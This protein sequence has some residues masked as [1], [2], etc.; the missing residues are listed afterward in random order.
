MKFRLFFLLL[1]FWGQLPAQ[2]TLYITDVPNNTPVDA[3]IYVA[4]SFQGWDPG[5]PDYE[6][7]NNGDGTYEIVINPPAGQLKFKFTRGGWD[8][9]EGNANGEYLPDRIYDYDGNGTSLDLTILS[10]EDTGGSGSSTAADNVFILDEDFYMPQLNRNRRIWM[11]LPPD[12]DVSDKYYPVLYMHDGQNL[13]D[14][15]TSFTG[16]WEVDESLNELFSQGDHGAI[17]VGIDNGQGVRAD[18]Y[19][20][21]YNDNYD[22]GGQGAAYLDF[23][24]E[25]LKPFIDENYRTL[26]GR[27]H[28]CLFGSSLGG[29][30]SQFGL[31]EH[32]DVFGKA[33]VFSP[34]FWFNPEIFDHSEDTPKNEAMKVYMLAGIP[35]GNGSV[36]DDVN[37]MEIALFNN[38]FAA[39]EFNKAFHTDGQHSEWYWAREFPW[40]Y[41]WLF[42]G[43]DLTDA[44]EQQAANI[45]IF[46]NPADTMLFLDN[47]PDLRRPMVRIFSAD[48]KL[49][50]KER[51]NGNS[52]DVSSLQPG[53]YVLN[54]RAKRKF[55]YTQQIIVY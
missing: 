20:P 21:W 40:A 7:T 4:G 37:Q 23:I 29:L 17:V 13:F 18:E 3:D 53:V 32:Q 44:S 43:M 50:Q 36:V 14:M 52:V 48:G 22:A 25:T 54:V 15:Q 46:P 16:E 51:L 49:A 34:A 55:S 1:L 9:V 28:T 10:W 35:E 30:I 33:G 2:L 19:S 47:M 5:D 24:V 11:Y 42:N 41:L 26:V 27:E 45:R 39:D 8:S 31:M 12:Y 38:G 6:L